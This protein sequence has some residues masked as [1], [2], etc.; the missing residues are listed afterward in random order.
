MV[1][2]MFLIGCYGSRNEIKKI[3][4]IIFHV[5][6]FKLTQDT[7]K[8]ETFWREELKGGKKDER[9]IRLIKLVSL[10]PDGLNFA[11]SNLNYFI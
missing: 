4:Q 10:K 9:K 2:P 5:I 11:I 3:F 6:L 8:I 1:Y 7:S